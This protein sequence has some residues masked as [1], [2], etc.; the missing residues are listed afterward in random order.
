MP[1]VLRMALRPSSG[2]EM[3]QT[4]GM[5]PLD[6]PVGEIIF[7]GS[8]DRS[9]RVGRSL[10]RGGC[11]AAYQV[12]QI[13]GRPRLKGRLC[14]KVAVETAA[15]HREAYF[16]ELLKG[17]PRAV[18]IHDTFATFAIPDDSTVIPLYCLV[19]EFAP[20]GDLRAYLRKRPKPWPERRACREVAEL[21][22]V[23]IRLHSA[24]A[25][26]RDLTPQNV[27]VMAGEVL[28]LGDFG[29]ARHRSGAR[30]VPADIFNE[31]GAPT[32]IVEGEFGYWH[33]ADD[34]Y[35]M[36]G[37]LAA[38]ISGSADTKP[39]IAAVKALRC[40]S[41]MK[42]II[43]RSIGERRKRFKDAGAMLDALTARGGTTRKGPRPTS[44]AGKTV[45][46]TGVLPISRAEAGRRAKRA[47]AVIRNRITSETDILVKGS[48]PPGGWKADAKGQKLLEVDRERE[49][50][51]E[52][53]VIGDRAF[54][55]LCGNSE[56]TQATGR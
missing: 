19:S 41:W 4:T 5:D 8:S 48:A 32:T 25:V 43:Q 45:V 51:H 1:T 46:F 35:Q 53:H 50:G 14:L 30:A 36:G 23:L 34:V 18:A 10:G 31:G 52:I 27:L 55:A 29:I 40:S 39:S 42:A 44:L 38:L 11:G 54:L 22:R 47:G 21:L 3:F 13:G 15:W 12:T 6:L 16:G 17:V 56:Q 7:D 33:S 2:F 24:G 26:H 28:K 20:Y 49:R 37:I 9:Y